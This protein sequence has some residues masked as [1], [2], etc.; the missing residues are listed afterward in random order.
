[1]VGWLSPAGGAVYHLRALRFGRVRWSPF[2]RALGEWLDDWN[3]SSDSVLLVG[4]SAG[5]CLADRVLARFRDV[6]V[7]EPDPIARW[8]LSRR[9][10]RLGTP[11]VRI[12]ADDLL[13]GGLLGP[14][15]DVVDLLD[16]EPARAVLFCNVLGQVRFLLPDDAFDM[17]AG[18]FRTRVVPALAGREW[19]SF[20]DRV[21]GRVAPELGEDSGSATALDDEALVARFYGR[22]LAPRTAVELVDHL[23]S[24]LWAPSLARRYFTWE[25]APGRFHL[26]EGVRSPVP[27]PL[28]ASAR[29][30]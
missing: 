16:A 2:E 4:P 3:P 1:M 5:Y 12:C 15:R 28:L 25:L 14:G 19:A 30:R 17:W 20:H 7:L 11:R 9:L 22:P 26:I 27:L 8:L 23:A 6:L 13:V 24:G 10:A 29:G 21:S 18:A